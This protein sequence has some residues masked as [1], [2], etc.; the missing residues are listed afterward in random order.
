M[1]Y[2]LK[3]IWN[4]LPDGARMLVF[5]WL[6]FTTVLLVMGALGLL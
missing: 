3:R 5:L 1:P 2:L 4:R 6:G